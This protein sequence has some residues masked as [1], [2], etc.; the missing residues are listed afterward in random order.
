MARDRGGG[1]LSGGLPAR[2]GPEGIEPPRPQPSLSALD[3]P[4]VAALAA[5]WEA[6]R[7]GRPFPSRGEID[8]LDIPALLPDLVLLD[9]LPPPNS[10]RVRLFGTRLA[11][12]NSADL[13]GRLL[14]DCGLGE[15]YAGFRAEL[16]RAC[17][18]QGPVFFE[19][20]FLWR[21]QR[22]RG[23]RMGVFPLGPA[24]ERVDILLG[25]V[26]MLAA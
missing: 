13:T 1:W 23:F 26:E 17:D 2:S 16:D 12:A 5:Y 24:P 22:Y 8:P 10:Y 14:E 4:L 11:A 19:S 6:R 3:S 25:G 20:G 18:S 21:R 7:D 9:V 15:G